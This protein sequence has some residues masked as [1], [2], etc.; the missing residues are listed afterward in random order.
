VSSKRRLRRR[1]ER[2]AAAAQWRAVMRPCR[3]GKVRSQ[4]R[5]DAEEKYELAVAKH[6]HRDEVR[7]YACEFGGWHW[8]RILDGAHWVKP[9][10]LRVVRDEQSLTPEQEAWVDELAAAAA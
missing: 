10:P 5:Q 6:G 2:R 1:D 7:F 4:D 3:C 9:R 8:T